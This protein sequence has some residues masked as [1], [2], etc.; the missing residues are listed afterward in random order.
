MG[1]R[2][3]RQMLFSCRYKHTCTLRREQHCIYLFTKHV[4]ANYLRILRAFSNHRS[5]FYCTRSQD[6]LLLDNH[7]VNT[8]IGK[9]IFK[10][11][12]PHKWNNLQKILKLDKLITFNPF[13]QTSSSV[14][15]PWI[16]V[17][18]SCSWLSVSLTCLLYNL[19]TYAVT[20][21]CFMCLIVKERL[22]SM[23]F[24]V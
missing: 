4:L 19:L 15:F 3:K 16:D 6:F 23:A 22:F 1:R 21:Y 13:W 7:H 24:P 12:A 20:F 18:D 10:Y 11:H 8:E 17:A 2:I 9:L 5:I 14:C